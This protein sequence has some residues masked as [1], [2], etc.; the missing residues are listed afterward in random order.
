MP[1]GSLD[2]QRRCGQA[3]TTRSFQLCKLPGSQKH[4]RLPNLDRHTAALASMRRASQ[5]HH[6][7]SPLQPA[8][9]REGGCRRS[10]SKSCLSIAARA[11]RTCQ[12]SSFAACRILRTSSAACAW[13]KLSRSIGLYAPRPLAI[14]IM[15]RWANGLH[16]TCY[17]KT[18]GNLRSLE[19]RGTHYCR[20][21]LDSTHMQESADLKSFL[22]GKPAHAIRTASRTPPA[23][24]CSRTYSG[25]SWPGLDSGLGLM[26][27]MKCGWHCFSVPISPCTC[28]PPSQA[29]PLVGT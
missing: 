26:Q 21:D 23:L 5:Q 12:P 20:R 29:A 13:S 1:E 18:Y 27:R 28:G 25:A 22:V 17:M 6:C 14:R 4:P 24:S 2:D 19:S 3:A 11:R 7:Y 16:S 9:T 10:A 8:R 15:Y